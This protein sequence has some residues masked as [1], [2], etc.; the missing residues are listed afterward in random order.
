MPAPVSSLIARM[1]AS[2]DRQEWVSSSDLVALWEVASTIP[3]PRGRRGTRYP[4]ATILT[5]AQRFPTRSV[6]C[7]DERGDGVDDGGGLL[8]G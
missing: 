5:L 6:T 3:D 7:G 4:L 8:R 1:S 2:C